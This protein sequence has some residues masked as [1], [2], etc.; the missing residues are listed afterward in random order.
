M[1]VIIHSHAIQRALE[2]GAKK[3]QITD[4]VDNGEKFPAKFNRTGFRKNFHHNSIWN[5]KKYATKQIEEYCVN[6]NG[7]WVVV[8][9]IV[10]Y[11]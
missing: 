1:S 2:R 4:T 11:F 8:T 5:G 10:K 6:E 9:V 3:E 7:N